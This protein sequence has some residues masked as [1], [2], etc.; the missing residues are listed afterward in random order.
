[1]RLPPKQNTPV[2]AAPRQ[3]LRHLVRTS[4]GVCV[5][6]SAS[7]NVIAPVGSRLMFAALILACVGVLHMVRL[8]LEGRRNAPQWGDKAVLLLAAANL[9][10]TMTPIWRS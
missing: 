5:L 2:S 10:W 7:L 9:A 3:H 6:L 1:M 4:V 8:L